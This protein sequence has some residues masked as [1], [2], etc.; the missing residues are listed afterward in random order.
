MLRTSA[1]RPTQFYLV[2]LQGT[3][4]EIRGLLRLRYRVAS[5]KFF[6]QRRSTQLV[7]PDIDEAVDVLS[8]RFAPP[9]AA[10]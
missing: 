7:L 4:A 1:P 6:A 3:R 10:Y 2:R 8:V 9:P 5:P